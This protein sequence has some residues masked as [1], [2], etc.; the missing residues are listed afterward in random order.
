VTGFDGSPKTE[1][2]PLSLP[3]G[4]PPAPI[5]TGIVEAAKGKHAM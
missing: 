3:P 1:L 5:V 4:P 2:S